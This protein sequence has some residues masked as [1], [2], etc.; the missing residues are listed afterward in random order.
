MEEVQLNGYHK[1][2]KIRFGLLLAMLIL[3]YSATEAQTP[4]VIPAGSFIVNMGVLPQT[5]GNGL[6]PYG[7]IYDLLRNYKVPVLWA[8]NTSK[9]KDGVD[10]TYGGADFKGGPFIIET[11]YR[12]AA[13]NSRIAYWQGLGVVGITTTESVT[14]PL[15]MTFNNAPN[16]TLD[17]QNGTIA[18][19]F[20]NYAGIPSSAYG[21]S[22]KTSWKAPSQLGFCDD[23]FVM[24]HAD[25]TWETHKRLFDWNLECR[26]AIWLGCH[27]GSA[28]ED[29]FD[30][31]P[32]ANYDQQTNFLAEK[33]GPAWGTGP[34]CENALVLWGN[35]D[36]GT[37]PYT[38]EYSGDPVM[39]FMG[40]LDAAT[41]NGSEQIYI[42][43]APGWRPTTKICV[44]D[45]DHPQRY[46]LSN[47]VKHRAA[48][49]AYGPGFGIPE[50]EK[51]MVQAAHNIS[52]TTPACV[53]AQ[54]TFFNFSFMVAN[55][56]AVVPKITNLPD[57]LMSG[58]NYSFYVEFP[59]GI[60]PANYKIK[61]SS[62]CGVTF[63]PND[64]VQ[65]VFMAAPVTQTSF[66]CMISVEIKD[67]CGRVSFDTKSFWLIC[68]TAV[69][70]VL[71]M[72]SC[73]GA[74]DGSIALT[75]T[76]GDPPYSWAWTRNSPPGGNSGT[77]ILISGLMAGQYQITVTPATGCPVNFNVI[78]TQPPLLTASTAAT[79]IL[80][81]G[82]TGSID[83]TVTG[84]TSPYSFNWADGPVSEDRAGVTAGTYSVTVT[85]AHACKTY[86][87]A[88]VTEP[89]SDISIFGIITDVSCFGG[90]DGAV[91]LT[92]TGGTPPYS[93]D[94]GGGI[95]SED[96][97]ALF[98]GTYSV[99]VRDANG[100]TSSGSFLLSQ[101]PRL[102]LSILKKNET[103][104]GDNDGEI[105]I[106]VNGGT[107]LYVFDWNDLSHPPA[108]PEDRT[109]LTEGI[110]S[111]LV[112]D[113]KGCQEELTVEI[114]SE[115]QNPVPPGMIKD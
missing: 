47:E 97:N 81:K 40:T 14:V 10:F 52:G 101:P 59:S 113:T 60:N 67:E 26:G 8:I 22:S 96:R 112:T 73:F 80:C 16:W 48:V 11:Q 41:Q 77:G 9:A 74:A 49:L 115:F 94:W 63:N 87:S 100:C 90:N 83:V 35:H 19:N 17:F 84:G 109:G 20:F 99:I 25:P 66:R 6:K 2:K 91:N 3:T 78:M 75:V 69:N 105:N 108:E 44:Y 42:P 50:R 32:P 88:V 30:Y 29:L 43:L 89:L 57:T 70:R 13:V 62:T 34:V 106:T 65:Y 36:D 18:V 46:N 71:T 92:V 103:C 82:G 51:V 61:W 55:E 114:T 15:Y 31:E 54:R 5:V 56:K 107:P 27:A 102:V 76:D 1:N 7:M 45:P 104:P 38:Y 21:G 58:E 39:Q 72:P 24:P 28:L 12:S 98:P 85:D 86:T 64:S 33:T 79:P 110:Y 4:T 68:R 37:P 95:T 93:F 53:A 111:V 23:M